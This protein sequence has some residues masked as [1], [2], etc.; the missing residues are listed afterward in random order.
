MNLETNYISTSGMLALSQC[1]ANPTTWRFLQSIKLENQRQLVS[2]RAELELAKA[3]CKNKS[4]IRCSLRVRNLWEREQINKFVSRNMD[5]LRQARL[6]HAKEAGIHVQRA[7]N[8]MEQLFDRVAADDP[9]LTEI[10][11]VGNQV[12]LSLPRDEILK[13]AWA[14]AANTHVK[15]VRMTMLRLDDEVARALAKSLKSNTSITNLAL[16][17]N[18]IGGEGIVEL[19]RSLGENESIVEVQLRHQYVS[20]R[21]PQQLDR[22]S[23]LTLVSLG[24]SPSR[25]QRKIRSQACSVTTPFFAS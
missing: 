7:R 11:V 2:S 14:F 13:A 22:K 10:E 19:V 3:L 20:T 12:F 15:I 17:S 4:V 18:M 23:L 21:E 9:T 5:F 25:P 6:H 1:L 24:R 8:A 16:D